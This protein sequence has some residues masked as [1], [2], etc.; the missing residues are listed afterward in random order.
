[1][2]LQ[3]GTRGMT[4][5][6]EAKEWLDLEKDDTMMGYFYVAKRATDKWPAGKRRPISEKTE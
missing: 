5:W 6:P 1:M 3:L 4:F 2:G